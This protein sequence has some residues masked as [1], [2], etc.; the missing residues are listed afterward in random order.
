[1]GGGEAAR[2]GAGK[3][4]VEIGEALG[5]QRGRGRA[6]RALTA[7]GWEVRSEMGSWRLAVGAERSSDV[8][9]AVD[10][11]RVEDDGGR[12]VAGGA[13]AGTAKAM[14]PEGAAP[15][16]VQALPTRAI[17]WTAKAEGDGFGAGEG[18]GGVRGVGGLDGDL[19]VD[20]T[21]DRGQVDANG[22]TVGV[23]CSDRD[24]VGLEDLDDEVGGGLAVEVVLDGGIGGV[25]IALGE[26]A[27]GDEGRDRGDVTSPK[28]N[29]TEWALL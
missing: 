5:R 19:G 21:L 27:A 20:D 11:A 1:M 18:D 8:E 17:C 7:A 4:S 16:S 15:W 29:W 3:V 23:G 13:N 26:I 6:G 25:E 24:R 22:D 10:G 28:L 14:S 2:V 9:A 12:L